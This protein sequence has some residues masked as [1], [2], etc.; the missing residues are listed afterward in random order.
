MLTSHDAAT[1][2]AFIMEGMRDLDYS[3]MIELY[4][5]GCL[6]M[7]MEATQHV[8]YLME[9][10]E[11][12]IVNGCDFPGVL[13]YEVC[14]TFGRWFGGLILAHRGHT[15]SPAMARQKMEELV[16]AFFAQGESE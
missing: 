10:V 14:S 5:E 16:D 4:S 2:G 11:E 1:Y 12:H 8:P 7:V 6:E 15:P 9:M 13:D 3:E